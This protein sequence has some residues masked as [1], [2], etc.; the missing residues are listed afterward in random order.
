MPIGIASSPEGGAF[1][2]FHFVSLFAKGSPFGGAGASAPE[3][4]ICKEHSAPGQAAAKA[5]A[6]D[7]LP[8]LQLPGLGQ[9]V[10]GYRDAGG[11]TWGGMI[12]EYKK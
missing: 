9:L 2:F 4:V 7:R 8:R 12:V 3:R 6:G 11:L 1:S 10:Q 5:D